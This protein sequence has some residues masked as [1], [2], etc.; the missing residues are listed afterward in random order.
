ME[1]FIV[2]DNKQIGP[3]EEL[4]VRAML[5]SGEVTVTDKAWCLLFKDWVPLSDL[6][7]LVA[8]RP[9][10]VVVPDVPCWKWFVSFEGRIGRLT[11]FKFCICI[12][13][14]LC[15]TV[16]LLFLTSMVPRRFYEY[17][18]IAIV[19]LFVIVLVCLTSVGLSIRCRRLHDLGFSGW[20]QLLGCIPILNGIFDLFLLFFPGDGCANK[21]GQPPK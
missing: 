15:G 1:I 8:S 11:F 14:I 19:L 21:F 17:F 7:N 2:K 9:R 16:S 18:Y 6:L 5:A 12:V 10:G 20:W 3:F 4:T 13:A